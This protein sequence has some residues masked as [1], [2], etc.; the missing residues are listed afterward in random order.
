MAS[1]CSLPRNVQNKWQIFMKGGM[2]VVPQDA[3]PP[4]S[5]LIY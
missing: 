3:I 5:F 1:V 2:N 4:L